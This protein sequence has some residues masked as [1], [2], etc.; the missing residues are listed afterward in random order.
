MYMKSDCKTKRYG[1][2]MFKTF[3]VSFMF[4]SVSC[5]SFSKQIFF[6]SVSCISLTTYHVLD[7]ASNG[8]TLNCA[9]AFAKEEKNST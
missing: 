2:K 6:N 9:K 8:N 3:H 4:N 5:I 7:T 1:K